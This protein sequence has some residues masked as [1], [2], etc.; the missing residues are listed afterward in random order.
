MPL[1]NSFH[2]LKN[3]FETMSR[4][5]SMGYGFPNEP[6]TADQFGMDMPSQGGIG[7]PQPYP[8]DEVPRPNAG[9]IIPPLHPSMIGAE[10]GLTQPPLP[11]VIQPENIASQQYESGYMPEYDPNQR[12]LELYK[13]QHD[14]QERLSA[15]L[16][17][18]PERNKPGIGRKIAASL[19]GFGGG[20]RAADAAL[21][22]P[23]HHA[24][25]DWEMKVRPTQ[26][27]A[28]LER[29]ENANERQLALGTMTREQAERRLQMDEK[30]RISKEETDKFKADTSRMRAEAYT[31][32]Q[33]HPNSVFKTDYDGMLYA[34]NPQTNEVV[35]LDIDTKKL[36]DE[37]KIRLQIQGRLDVAGAQHG[38][39]SAEI[40]QR[41]DEAR[42]TKKTIP[43]SAPKTGA[44]A[45]PLTPS[46]KVTDT[47]YRAG[48]LANTNPR[49][50]NFVTVD[51]RKVT[52]KKPGERNGPT[53]A[54]YNQIIEHLYPDLG[55]QREILRGGIKEAKGQ[56]V[57]GVSSPVGGKAAPKSKTPS[58]PVKN[59]EDRIIVEALDGKGRFSLPREQKERA[60]ARGYK[61]IKE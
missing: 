2:R 11:D 35:P 41:G 57:R 38:Y 20:P 61:V 8:F 47:I 19:V 15:L 50:G 25:E 1:D 51:G 27:E 32:K 60:I 53:Q 10:G 7:G 45:K 43:G 13:P 4:T 36:N 34:I 37:D 3:L 33:Y 5:N 39:R 29:Y 17:S 44:G 24:V 28:N 48:E 21:Y 12:M 49:L 18:A 9:G 40:A 42:E 59:P 26:Y 6:S 30:K 16:A 14:A 55:A 31:Y 58:P 46:A 23:Y 52:V 56:E 22:A 54:E